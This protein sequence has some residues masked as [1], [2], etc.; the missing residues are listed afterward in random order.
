VD[1]HFGDSHGDTGLNNAWLSYEEVRAG[2]GAEWKI[3]SSFSLTIG[4]GYVPWRQ[5]DFHRAD[6]RY[7][8]ESG[9]PFGAIMLH[10]AF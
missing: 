2:V 5:F 9:A 7:H 6:V 8:Y 4:G 10:G 3:N 1:D